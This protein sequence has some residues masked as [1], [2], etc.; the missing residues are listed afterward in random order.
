MDLRMPVM[1]GWS[2]ARAYRERPGPHAPIIVLTALAEAAE[3][4]AEVGA[5]GH[6]GKPFELAEVLTI[7]AHQVGSLS[8]TL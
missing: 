1:D 7:V 4:A 5:N 3:T 2:F 8:N 6:V